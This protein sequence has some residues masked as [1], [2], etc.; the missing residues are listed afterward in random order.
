MLILDLEPVFQAEREFEE[1]VDRFGRRTHAAVQAAVTEAANEARNTRRYQDQTGLLTSR[2]RGFV[3]VSAPGGAT[4][5]IGAFTDYASFVDSGTKAH[6]IRARR[7][8][9]LIFKTRDGQ[10]VSTEVVQH[11]GTAPDGFVGRAFQKA[12]R[13]LVREVEIATVELQRFLDS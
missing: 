2:I 12:E 5:I 10:W 9:R 7:V 8:P 3:E 1:G 13:V 11:P 6:E 4:G